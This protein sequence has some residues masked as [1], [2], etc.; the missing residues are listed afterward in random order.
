MS[1]AEW[2]IDGDIGID[3]AG[4][5]YATWD[6]QGTNPDGSVNDIGWLSFSADHGAH[7]S[8][9]VQSPAARPTTTEVVAV[10]SKVGHAWGGKS[11][12]PVTVWPQPDSSDELF[13]IVACGIFT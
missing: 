7:W 4:N 11:G 5:P 12:G 1:L 6:T 2:W 8:A 10:V 13:G 3:S 9:P